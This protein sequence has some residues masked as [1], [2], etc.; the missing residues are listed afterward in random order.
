M[1]HQFCVCAFCCGRWASIGPA[2][3]QRLVFVGSVDK[4]HYVSHIAVCEDNKTVAQ[5]IGPKDD[6][7]LITIAI[8]TTSISY[9]LLWIWLWRGD[10]YSFSF[11]K[12]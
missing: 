6:I 2:L 12:N 7:T 10:N 11:T 5:L 4:P 9:Q 3:S 8:D 1:S